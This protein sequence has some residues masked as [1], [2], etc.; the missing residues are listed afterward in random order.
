MD[1]KSAYE[2]ASERII[3]SR[4][5]KADKDNETEKKT[6][7]F[8]EIPEFS[9]RSD[10]VI[11]SNE[12]KPLE[13]IKKME[14]EKKEKKEKDKNS[15]EEVKVQE[16]ERIYCEERPLEVHWN[17]HFMG[18]TGFSRLNRSMV[19]GLSNRNVKV[20]TDIEPYLNHVNKSTRDL[21][22][23]MSESKIS[24]KA[25]K[26]Y[27]VTSPLD[28]SHPGRK[29]VY[30]MIETSE[31]VH[32][33]YSG[34]LNLVDEIWVPTEYGKKILE[35]SNIHPP[36]Y[37]M[38]LGV[39]ITRYN[40]DAKK[41]NIKSLNNFVFISVFR[42]SWRKGFD[43]LLRSYMEE[44]SSEDNVSL[45]LVSRSVECPEEIGPKQILQDFNDIKGTINKS[46]EEFPH[47]SLYTNP[48]PEMKMP[49]F[50]NSANA[51]VLM[52]RGEGFG[53]PYM[54]AS[55]CG[56]PVIA[57]NCSGHS[58]FLKEDNS[59]LVEPDGYVK[60]EVTGNLNK[61]A[62]MC[63]FYEGQIFPDFG[64]SAIEKTKRH[65]RFVFE[66][67]EEA[68]EKNEKLKNVIS[69]Q[70]TWDNAVDRVYGRLEEINRS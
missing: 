7:D 64:R 34:K 57:S 62:K 10:K 26:V 4:Y 37:V 16:H 60:A 21:L 14:K 63:R 41:M 49:R 6:F 17:G 53:L 54:E 15:C 28:M 66:N 47:I 13:E 30:T 20:K 31:K 42:W 40:P 22:E 56:L 24:P 38:P 36:I 46:E 2:L 23:K 39:D 11:E 50:Y 27:G 65:M 69:K 9:N 5:Q 19:F 12:T 51:F 58:D 1:L 29:I 33:D 68:K 45:L 67:E 48:I 18:Y 8:V 25:P 32:K 70:Y 3:A 35:K 52:S 43:I 44:F 59:Y 61:M 55:A